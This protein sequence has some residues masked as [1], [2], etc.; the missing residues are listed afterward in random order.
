MC[1]PKQIESLAYAR[2][3]SQDQVTRVRAPNT[4]TRVHTDTH[5]HTKQYAHASECEVYMLYS[6]PCKTTLFN[7]QSARGHYR[8]SMVVC[9]CVC[10]AQIDQKTRYHTIHTSITPARVLF[11]SCCTHMR[12]PLCGC[13]C[14]HCVH[15]MCN[16]TQVSL[17]Y[18][19]A[20]VS[21]V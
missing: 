19:N 13:V 5:I 11:F 8:N 6:E 9:A 7:F 3:M 2:H 4:Y 10:A 17:V 20:Y 21:C 12:V 16:Y 1:A 15:Y 18:I 14:V